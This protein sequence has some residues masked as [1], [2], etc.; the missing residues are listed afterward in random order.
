VK[1]GVS[2]TKIELCDKDRFKANLSNAD[3]WK[4]NIAKEYGGSLNRNNQ[5]RKLRNQVP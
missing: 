3:A 5:Q 2:G 1:V 4:M